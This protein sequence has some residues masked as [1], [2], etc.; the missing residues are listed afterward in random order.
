MVCICINKNSITGF[1]SHS[2]ISIK[3][4][5]AEVAEGSGSLAL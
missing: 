2:L 3:H 4:V 1:H 5:F